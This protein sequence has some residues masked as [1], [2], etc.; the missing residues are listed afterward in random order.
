MF[1]VKRPYVLGIRYTIFCDRIVY[2]SKY[3]S[4]SYLRNVRTIWGK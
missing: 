4:I 2:L 1:W 3:D